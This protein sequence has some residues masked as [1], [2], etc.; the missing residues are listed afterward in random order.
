MLTWDL[1]SDTVGSLEGP[2]CV[3]VTQRTFDN[4]WRHAFKSAPLKV[5]FPL[6]TP[7]VRFC[8]SQRSSFRTFRHAREAAFREGRLRVKLHSGEGT[9]EERGSIFCTGRQ[10]GGGLAWVH[11]NVPRAPISASGVLP[12]APEGFQGGSEGLPGVTV[13]LE[14]SRFKEK[15]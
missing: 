7:R 6:K 11:R 10:G 13:M 8:I 14:E 4:F 3:P 2:G 1:L 9:G 12:R 15:G 5:P